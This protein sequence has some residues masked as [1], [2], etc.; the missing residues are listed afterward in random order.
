MPGLDLAHLGN[1]ILSARKRCGLTQKELAQQTGLSVKTIQDT[2][3]GRK[4]PSYRTLTRL[5]ERLGIP[6]DAIFQSKAPI[7]ADVIQPF[8][9]NF[10][11]CNSKNQKILLKT[12][13]FL[14]EQLRTSQ[15]QPEE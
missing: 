1:L 4:K 11:S 14:A 15:E 8:L 7:P 3:K 6:P 9:E 2:E 13:H 12:M 10:H 5:I